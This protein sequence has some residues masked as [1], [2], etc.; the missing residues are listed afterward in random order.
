VAK[1]DAKI[2]MDAAVKSLESAAEQGDVPDPEHINAA[3][4][5]A[6]EAAEH[7]EAGNK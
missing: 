2:H 4:N 3:T 7:L 5:A 1:G 6:E